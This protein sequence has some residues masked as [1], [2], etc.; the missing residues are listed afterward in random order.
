M[1][2]LV[3]FTFAFFALFCFS[4]ISFPQSTTDSLLSLLKIAKEDTDKVKTLNELSWELLNTG[5]FETSLQYANSA[6][7]LAEKLAFKNGIANSYNNI[8]TVYAQ[9]GNYPEALK[10][11]LSALKINEEVNNKEGI[12]IS[13]GNIGNV[14]SY[15]DNYPEALKNISAAL[16]I[17]EEIGN[18][19]G[20]AYSYGN[21]GNIYTNQGNYPEALKNHFA[22]LMIEEEIGDKQGIADSYNNIGNVYNNQGNFP[23]ALKNYFS[24]LKIQEEIGDKYGMANSFVNLCNVYN[25]MK[26][27]YE[28]EA[29]GIK[30][31]N[32]ARQIGGLE[33]VKEA[34]EILSEVYENTGS[35]KRALETYKDYVMSR[36]SLLNKENTKKIVQTQMQYEFDKKEAV[37][38]AEQDKK[39]ALTAQEKQKQK[40]ITYSVSAGLFLVLL[41][42]LFI[43][44]GYRQKQK[45]NH[46]LEEK[47]KD[48][49]DSITYARRIQEAILIPE[50]EIKKHFTDVF[51]L[52]KP[53]DIVSGDFY[54]FGESKY[55]KVIAAADCTGHG[56]PG[57]FMCMLGFEML[58][59]TLLQEEIK[60][61]SHALSL[62]DKKITE[63]LNRN[64][65]SYR[66]GMD[67]VLCAFSKSTNTLQ[68]SCANRPLI[69][70]R[71]GVLQEFSPDR[72]TI[73]GAIDNVSKNFTDREIQ[74]EK[75]DVIY[76][77]S[78][79]YADQFGGPK[80]KKFMYRKLNEK[81]S[82]ISHLSLKLQKDELEKTF[83][84]WKGNLEQVDDVTVMGI[85][86]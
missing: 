27:Y 21:I 80:G 76:L 23:E 84:E 37:T 34:N 18:K 1:K 66:D 38:K 78:D 83:N 69:L 79:G 50:N 4:L 6:K 47:N 3:S 60:T 85:K 71:N 41:L 5:D 64:N 13:Y 46:K 39:D 61:T 65:R 25:K 52:F 55:N 82:A 48:I 68:F 54:W 19:Q 53:K 49:T 30:A 40:I 2:K 62:L 72:N 32:L 12:A 67:M 43:L 59:E 9:Q 44:R 16:K 75:G 14:Y 70:I 7:N 26:N 81:L 56:V 51:V 35:H 86:I 22:D 42:A 31:L 57:G 29:Y 15:Q 45:L 28:A 17:E 63:T 77:F 74:I 73:G 20:I 58:Q 10:I 33:N 24:S 11:F 8:G 36:D